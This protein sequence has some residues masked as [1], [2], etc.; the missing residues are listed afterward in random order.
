MRKYKFQLAF[1]S[2][3]GLCVV[4]KL[5]GAN[6]LSTILGLLVFQLQPVLNKIQNFDRKKLVYIK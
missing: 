4:K 1:F 3:L 2:E 5:P 6:L